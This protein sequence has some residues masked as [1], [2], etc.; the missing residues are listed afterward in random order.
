MNYT[1]NYHLPQ[2]EESDRIMRTDFNAA[3][4]NIEEG[5]T[6]GAKPLYAMGTYR[7]TEEV[8]EI[9][10]GFRPSAVLIHAGYSSN[11][12]VEQSLDALVI[13]NYYSNKVQFTDTGFRLNSIAQVGFYP[14]VNKK[15]WDYVYLA[16]R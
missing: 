7:G 12:P 10:I 11:V 2:W 16:L 13:G 4:A 3:M 14:M 15:G 9:E 5:M 6:D 1:E 8:Q